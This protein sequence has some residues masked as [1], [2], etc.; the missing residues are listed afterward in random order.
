MSI[1]FTWRSCILRGNRSRI[2]QWRGEILW[3]GGLWFVFH[4]GPSRPLKRCLGMWFRYL[5]FNIILELRIG[6]WY[7]WGRGLYR[8]GGFCRSPR[9]RR[10]RG[11]WNLCF[12]G[13]FLDPW[14][15]CP[16]LLST[17]LRNALLVWIWN[18]RC[19]SIW[20][21]CWEGAGSGTGYVRERIYGTVS[22]RGV[23]AGAGW[24]VAPRR[25][26]GWWCHCRG[27]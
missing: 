17:I 21:C 23:G 22:W 13:S 7:N 10:W 16:N 20:V 6:G 4:W 9:D 18:C 8:R 5:H 27:G 19:L 11:C 15:V 2:Q 1:C 3:R 24:E 14:N 12:E 25:S 26:R